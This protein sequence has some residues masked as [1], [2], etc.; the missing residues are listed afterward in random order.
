MNSLRNYE[1]LAKDTI[2]QT[3]DRRAS[4][5]ASNS[6]LKAATWLGESHLNDQRVREG[7][8]KKTMGS[9]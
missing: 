3:T 9:A 1:V 6:E 5:A 4:W 8:T 2:R 7:Q